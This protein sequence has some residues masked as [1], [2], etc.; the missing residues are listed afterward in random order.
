MIA[1]DTDRHRASVQ[2]LGYT[3]LDG[4]AAPSSVGWNHWDIPTAA[5]WNSSNT[6]TSKSPRYE[7]NITETYRGA[8]GAELEPDR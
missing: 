8:L 4:L 7:R 5:K 1:S 6:L 3:I 2:D